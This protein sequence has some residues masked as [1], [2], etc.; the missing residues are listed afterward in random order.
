MRNDRA[1]T[2]LA[3]CCFAWPMLAVAQAGAPAPARSA[4][5]A[6]APADAPRAVVV[7]TAAAMA[8][9]TELMRLQEDTVVLKAELKKLDAQAQ[10]AEREDALHRMGRTQTYDEITLV[11]TQSL[12]KTMSATVLTSD[13]GELDVRSG[14]TLPNGARVK[15]IRSG[16]MVLE[17]DGGRR[18]TLTVSSHRQSMRITAAAG[19]PNGGVPP[20][21][22][23]PMPTR[24][25]P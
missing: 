5:S 22:T 13:G 2:V 8:A 6:S 23:L 1:L 4:S 15:S 21:P 17:A 25:A 10:V 18:T 3:A 14:D 16:A 19:G 12:G 20:F 7:P 24:G 9:A 11:A